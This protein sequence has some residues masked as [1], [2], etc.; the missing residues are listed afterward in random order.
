MSY[1]SYSGRKN[2]EE[3]GS[4]GLYS[5]SSGRMYTEVKG[6]KIYFT[7]GEWA[8]PASGNYFNKD[9]Y[10]NHTWDFYAA[11]KR[12]NDILLITRSGFDH[13]DSYNSFQEKNRTFE[14]LT[15]HENGELDLS[16]SPEYSLDNPLDVRQ[17]EKIISKTHST[18]ET[19]AIEDQNLIQEYIDTGRKGS[20]LNESNPNQNGRLE[21]WAYYKYKELYPDQP[22]LEGFGVKDARKSNS[23]NST[24]SDKNTLYKPSKFNKKSADK[25]TNFN[26]STDTLEIDADSFG[27]NSSATFATAKNSKSVKKKLAKQDF[28]F[29]YDEKKGGLYFNENG[30]D[31]GFGDGG[32]IAI[33][34]GAPDLS[35]DN[36]E[37]I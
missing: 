12:G 5:D 29:L 2:L 35:A 22:M 14:V 19:W 24:K 20:Y 15:F 4:L 32:I 18:L 27:I 7:W 26:Q 31:K 6:E 37:F 1:S 10:G 3:D 36:L 8:T 9:W 33:L 28:D 30:S 17:L 23:G 25:I 11:E 13:L 16:A 34:K 21:E